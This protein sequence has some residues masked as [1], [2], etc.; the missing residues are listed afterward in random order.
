MLRLTVTAGK[1]ILPGVTASDP[2]LLASTKA[3]VA[4]IEK[5]APHSV[6]SS[7]HVL[8]AA[9]LALVASGGDPAKVKGIDATAV[10]SAGSAI[11]A[12]AKHSCG[13]DLSAPAP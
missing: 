8:G 10:Q 1:S 3:F 13:V 9:V 2:A 6:S 4:E 5:V 7:W 11:S 12:D